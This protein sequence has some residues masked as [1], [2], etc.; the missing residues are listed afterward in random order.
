LKFTIGDSLTISTARGAL[1]RGRL[2]LITCLAHV[3]HDG[4]ASMLY[5]LL[6]LWQSEF[7]L[8]F[9]EV[10]MLK[11]LYSAAMALGQVPVA[12]VGERWSE[13]PALVVGTF[14]TAAAVFALHWS[15]SPLVL[16]LLL[17]IGGLGASVQHPLASTLLAKAYRGPA[18]RTILGTYNFAG[19]LGKMI[20]PG[21]LTLLIAAAGWRHATEALG[22]LGLAI[23]AM[24]LA[25]LRRN[26]AGIRDEQQVVHRTSLPESVRRRGFVSLSAIGMLDSATR[27]GLLT[28][29]PFV[30][31]RKGADASG[32][33][34]ALSLV[35]A[36]GAAGKFACGTLATRLGVLRTVAVTEAATA[37]AIVLVLVL[38]LAACLALMPVLG[39]ALNGTSSVLYGTVPELTPSGREARG[40]GYF[41]T[42]T[43]GADA[44]APP[45]YGV[46]GD[47]IGLIASMLLVAAVVLLILP[48]LPLLREAIRHG[49]AT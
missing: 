15:V 3:L 9:A 37:V 16:G 31:A 24:L 48:L 46:A 19:D 11:T 18:L 26:E 43:I 32:I 41:Y 23:T 40:F 45:L 1:S 28:F 21:I 36:G 47:R 27:A 12:R 44:L 49:E 20:I 14:V 22:V 13:K 5:L 39:V 25:G 42:L 4:Y 38:P 8:N 29:L 34:L 6:P 35:F 7:S 10:G 30:L 33:G 17:A 2:F